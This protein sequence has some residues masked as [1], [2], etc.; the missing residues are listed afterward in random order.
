MAQSPIQSLTAEA[1]REKFTLIFFL[2]FGDERRVYAASI[3]SFQF[4]NGLREDL[5]AQKFI[6]QAQKI[7]KKFKDKTKTEMFHEVEFLNSVH[8]KNQYMEKWNQIRQQVDAEELALLIY[9]HQFGFS[10]Q[11]VSQALQL[12]EG[13]LR[14]RVRNLLIL[15]AQVTVGS[16]SG[17]LAGNFKVIKGSL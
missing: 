17:N 12:A 14:Y 9:I 15:L 6:Q 3:E 13:T 11:D 10:Y 8:K 1:A 4:I 5:S 16:R 7:L 2:V